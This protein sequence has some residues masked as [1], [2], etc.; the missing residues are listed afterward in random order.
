MMLDLLTVQVT[1]PKCGR[2]FSET[3]RSPHER[4]EDELP[5]RPDAGLIIV[6]CPGCGAAICFGVES[7]TRPGRKTVHRDKQKPDHTGCR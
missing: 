4:V 2:R 7:A 6:A 1:C 5:A 3:V